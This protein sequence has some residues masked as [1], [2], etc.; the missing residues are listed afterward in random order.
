M[1]YRIIKPEEDP[2]SEH[3]EHFCGMTDPF[4]SL[5]VQMDI[6]KWLKG[7]REA[8][9]PFFLSFLYEV[10]AA[11]NAVPELRRRIRDGQVIEF[12]VCESS[13]TAAAPDGTYRYC[14]VATNLPFEEY[15]ADARATQERAV[16]EEHLVETG[17]PESRFFISCVPWL[18]YSSLEMTKSA[19]DFSVPCITWGRYYTETGVRFENGAAL[20]DEHV[21]IPVTLM[22]NHALAD[23]I[24]MARFFEGLQNRLE[25]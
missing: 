9:Y 4:V 20:P 18:S 19:P 11:A 8:G 21:K 22:V 13:Y 10:G 2:R 14:D 5:T 1:S 17:D 3:F 25:Q 15:L 6:T 16:R 23:G 7:I 12:D 24:H